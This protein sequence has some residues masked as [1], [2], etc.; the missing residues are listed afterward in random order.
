M[1]HYQIFSTPKGL[2]QHK[3][4]VIGGVWAIHNSPE[5]DIVIEP[6]HTVLA[7]KK[8]VIEGS[9]WSEYSEDTFFQRAGALST[10]RRYQ[11]GYN[12]EDFIEELLGKLPRSPQRNLWIAL[13][14]LF[15]VTAVAA[16]L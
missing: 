5:M 14:G 8:H 15:F 12:C 9:G 7:G 13:I 2:V 4:L 3:I 10:K 11:L 6:L 1:S 16:R